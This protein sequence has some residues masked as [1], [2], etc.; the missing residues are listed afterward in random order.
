[1]Y[2]TWN[3]QYQIPLIWFPTFVNDA[4]VDSGFRFKLLTLSYFSLLTK[5]YLTFLL[6]LS[7]SYEFFFETE[8]HSYYPGWSAMAQ[9]RLMAT[10]ASWVQAI[11][12][13]QPPE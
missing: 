12:L 10:S 7:L 11:L 1:M 3:L 9:S 6:N 5:S 13:P 2:L 8:F 4:I